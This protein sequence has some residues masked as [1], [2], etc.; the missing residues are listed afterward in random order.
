MKKQIVEVNINELNETQL[1]Q[2]LAMIYE[3]ASHGANDTSEEMKKVA[4]INH[5]ISFVKGYMCKAKEEEY[6][7]EYC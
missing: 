3:N 7:K 5:R 1:E 4:K 2:L 6:R